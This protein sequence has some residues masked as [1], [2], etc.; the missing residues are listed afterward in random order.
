MSDETLTSDVADSIAFSM[1][2]NHESQKE[3]SV[4]YLL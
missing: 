3:V 1:I 4:C 2:A